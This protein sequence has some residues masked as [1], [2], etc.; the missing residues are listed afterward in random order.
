M[1][2]ERETKNIMNQKKKWMTAEK[3]IYWSLLNLT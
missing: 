2:D 1:T 3:M